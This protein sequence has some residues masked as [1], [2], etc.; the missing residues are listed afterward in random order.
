M[1]TSDSAPV[2]QRGSDREALHTFSSAMVSTAPYEVH[3]L[4]YDTAISSVNHQLGQCR[5]VLKPLYSGERT[6]RR[7]LPWL[8]CRVVACRANRCNLQTVRLRQ[9]LRRDSLRS[10]SR[11]QAKTGGKGIRTPDFQLAKLALYQLSYAPGLTD[12]RRSIF[13]RIGH[14]RKRGRRFSAREHRINSD[15]DQSAADIDQ[16]IARGRRSGGNERLVPFIADG[17]ERA[18]HRNNHK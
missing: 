13:A 4:R 6:R 3:G 14:S 15:S 18:H 2:L 5:T 12:F 10:P 16:D 7:M 11:R 8:A 9:E 17:K 1:Q